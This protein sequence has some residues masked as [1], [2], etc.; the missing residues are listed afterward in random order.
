MHPLAAAPGDADQVAPLQ[1]AEVLG[2]RR[3]R[4]R[5]LSGDLAGSTVLAHLQIEDSAAVRVGDG[6][7]NAFQPV[8]HNGRAARR[9]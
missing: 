2:H 8:G 4:D 6:A 5:E 7:E 1:H 3:T 9:N